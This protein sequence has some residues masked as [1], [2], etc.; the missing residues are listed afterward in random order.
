MENEKEKLPCFLGVYVSEKL[1]NAIKK[2]AKKE[3]GKDNRIQ[4]ALVRQALSDS[5]I[6]K[7]K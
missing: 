2:K 3:G 4:S 7:D 1:M 6:G 5:F